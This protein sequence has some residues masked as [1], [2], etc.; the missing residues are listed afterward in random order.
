MANPVNF[1]T[2]ANELMFGG[3]TFSESA[4]IEK[5]KLSY[6]ANKT[7]VDLKKCFTKSKKNG[8]NK[9]EQEVE[10]LEIYLSNTFKKNETA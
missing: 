9:A 10:F 3:N 4:L 7:L 8:N 5:F 2:I 1:E 6:R